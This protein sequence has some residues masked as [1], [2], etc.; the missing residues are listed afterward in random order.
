MTFLKRLREDSEHFTDENIKTFLRECLGPSC[1]K[2]LNWLCDCFSNGM[3]YYLEIESQRRYFRL[4]LVLVEPSFV[5]ELRRGAALRSLR[6]LF[7][8]CRVQ[9]IVEDCLD[10]ILTGRLFRLHRLHRLG[11]T[12]T[13][14]NPFCFSQSWDMNSLANEV[15]KQ[16]T[17]RPW[18][19]ISRHDW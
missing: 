1:T 14:P 13:R 12:S 17:S 9:R 5:S 8:L 7:L 10:E 4:P 3:K 6:R 19:L 2:E 11:Q 18:T 15:A 16:A